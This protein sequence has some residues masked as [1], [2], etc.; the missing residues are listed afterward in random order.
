MPTKRDACRYS[1]QFA[2]WEQSPS[3]LP[4]E[5]ASGF[6]W[7]SLLASKKQMKTDLLIPKKTITQNTMNVFQQAVK[8]EDTVGLQI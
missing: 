4:S 5:R 6:R 3:Q 8:K 1:N 7:Q 2:S